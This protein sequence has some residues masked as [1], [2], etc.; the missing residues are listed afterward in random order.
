MLES[1]LSEMGQGYKV[2]KE[3]GVGRAVLWGSGG[4]E[5]GLG[6]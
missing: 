3:P 2:M 5:V 4:R 1:G 6:N